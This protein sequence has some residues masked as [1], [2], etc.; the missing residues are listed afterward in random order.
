MAAMPVVPRSQGSSERENL[1]G[2]HAEGEDVEPLVG[3]P[4]ADEFRGHVVGR[5]GAIARLHEHRRGGHRQPEVDQLQFFAVLVGQQEVSRADVAMD[6]AGGM[7]GRDGLGGLADEV[8]AVARQA[9]IVGRP[10]PSSC[11]ARRGTP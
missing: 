9:R 11:R 6:E 7:H 4:A 3:R 8:D 5:A 1:V 2:R 10:A